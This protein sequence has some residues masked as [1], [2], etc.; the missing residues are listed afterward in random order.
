MIRPPLP[1]P[2]T[3]EVF[4]SHL[5]ESNPVTPHPKGALPCCVV[6]YSS[7]SLLQRPP[8]G[9]FNSVSQSHPH[10][11]L[12]P[13][14]SSA[15]ST[16]M[17]L[18]AIRSSGKISS[19]LRFRL[20]LRR[21]LSCS[22]SSKKVLRVFLHLDLYRTFW[23]CVVSERYQKLVLAPVDQ[24]FEARS[25]NWISRRPM[26]SAKCNLNRFAGFRS[27]V[28]FRSHTRADLY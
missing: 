6:S 23:Q 10:C 17:L 27:E 26:D 9:I 25:Q 8:S 7:S 4:L 21:P 13:R 20:L 22:S 28:I 16:F 24:S 19:S 15:A 12:V 18:E 5:E 2:G 1:D 14:L 11:D 3:V